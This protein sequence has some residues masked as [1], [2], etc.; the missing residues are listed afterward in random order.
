M[1]LP[2]TAWSGERRIVC[3]VFSHGTDAGSHVGLNDVFYG[4][5]II[6]VIIIPLIWITKQSKARL[7]VQ[8]PPPRVRTEGRLSIRGR[9]APFFC[10]RR[11]ASFERRP[12]YVALARHA[13]LERVAVIEHFAILRDPEVAILASEFVFVQ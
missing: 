1:E 9:G 8:A 5:A 3:V 2:L 11:V 10:R 4:A 13:R 7:A 12:G 6:M